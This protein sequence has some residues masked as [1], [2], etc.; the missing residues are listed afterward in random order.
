MIGYDEMSK[1]GNGRIFPIIAQQIGGKYAIHNFEKLP[2]I[3]EALRVIDDRYILKQVIIEAMGQ[4]EH[5]VRE[6]MAA[7]RNGLY[8][9]H[10]NRIKGPSRT[11][12]WGET[13]ANNMTKAERILSILLPI[14]QRYKVFIVDKSVNIHRLYNQILMVGIADHDDYAD[15]LS[16]TLKHYDIPAPSSYAPNPLQDIEISRWELLVHDH[17]ANA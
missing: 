6:V 11:Q 5:I 12:V 2:G 15:S 3:C 8:D 1:Y 4:Q 16:L 14:F 9:Q 13:V 10:G 7:F 17:G